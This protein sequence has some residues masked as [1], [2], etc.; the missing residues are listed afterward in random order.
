M[1]VPPSALTT[2]TVSGSEAGV[3]RS[4][5]RYTGTTAA[6]PDRPAGSEYS[7]VVAGSRPAE[8][9]RTVIGPDAVVDCT[10]DSS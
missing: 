4:V 5:R 3:P 10:I 2:C 9:T 6:G 1:L 8:D 7:V